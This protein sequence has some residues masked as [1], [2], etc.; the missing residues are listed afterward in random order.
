[1]V[2]L[3]CTDPFAFVGQVVKGLVE[4]TPNEVPGVVG[5]SPKFDAVRVTKPPPGPADGVI[6]STG[7]TTVYVAVA[8]SPR[9]LWAKK[10]WSP[11]VYT[12]S[13]TTIEQLSSEQKKGRRTPAS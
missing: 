5:G 8:R 13:S 10:T 9:L 12:G 11:G 2:Q 7:S 4:S 1:M 6:C 3:V